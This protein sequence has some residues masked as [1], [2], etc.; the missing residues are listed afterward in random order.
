MAIEKHLLGKVFI[1]HSSIDKPFV[2]R[3][4]RRLQNGGYQVWLDEK[5]LVPGDKLA[6]SVSKALESASVVLVVV[7][8]AAIKSKWLAFELNKATQKMIEGS[9]RVIPIIKEKVNLPPE[10]QGLLYADFTGSFVLGYKSVLTALKYESMKKATNAGFWALADVA[11]SRVFGGKSYIS[12]GG[13]YK[14]FDYEGFTL[15]YVTEDG[16]DLT[17]VYEEVSDYLKT[18]EPLTERWWHEYCEA[19]GQ[20]YGEDLF[21]VLTERAIGFATDGASSNSTRVKWKRFSDYPY[22]KRI[23]AFVDLCGLEQAKWHEHVKQSRKV[24]LEYATKNF[25]LEPIRED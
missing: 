1:S 3:L 11:A 12:V 4:S 20:N 7:S 9:C 18:K 13:E 23:A 19:K 16:N 2:R 21:L 10:V 5:E 22:D 6:E 25:K 17:V 14:S 24:L 15:P 8:S